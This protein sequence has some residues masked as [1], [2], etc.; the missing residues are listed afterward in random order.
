MPGWLPPTRSVRLATAAAIGAMLAVVILQL[1]FHG[2]LE[3]DAQVVLVM[4]MFL[5]VS[6]WVLTVARLA[7]AT[8]PC[9]GRSPD[10]GC[11]SGRHFR[12]GYC[13]GRT[14]LPIGFGGSARLRGTWSSSSRLQAGWPSGVVV[15]AGPPM[16]S[17][18]PLHISN[19]EGMS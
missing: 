14:A 8:A 7:T 4:A 2:C 16:F 6:T 12:P 19:E 15:G 5:L 17:K 9:P 1:L 3:F 18:L 11:C 13:R 10:S